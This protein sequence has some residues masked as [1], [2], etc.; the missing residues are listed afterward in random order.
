MTIKIQTQ[1]TYI[2][3][4]LGDELEL[5]FDVSDESVVKFRKEGA[6]INKELQEV[7]VKKDEEEALEQSK[8]VLERGLELFF[9]KGAFDD[10][11]KV[12]P[13]IVI[14]MDYFRQFAEVIESELSKMGYT[15]TAQD[16]ARK[17]LSKKK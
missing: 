11:Y 5:K 15:P 2:P 9:G 12:S 10:I 16:K 8:D 14:I 6:K 13:S 4:K 7:S 17:Y 1:K 3:I